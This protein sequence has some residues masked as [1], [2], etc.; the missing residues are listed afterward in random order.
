M[1]N[2]KEAAE[3]I[4]HYRAIRDTRH[5][6]YEFDPNHEA[7][8]GEVYP[9][10]IIKGRTREG[11]IDLQLV[12]AGRL[13][14]IKGMVGHRFAALEPDQAMKVF[15]RYAPHLRRSHSRES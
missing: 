5:L 15:N 11:M 3:R 6:V 7:F 2:L 12:H 8:P 4:V 14:L 1:G 9:T 10:E 13:H